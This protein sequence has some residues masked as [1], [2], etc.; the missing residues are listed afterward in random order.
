[1]YTM[2]IIRTTKK[3][4]E[5][6]FHITYIWYSYIFA[7]SKFHQFIIVIPNFNQC[8]YLSPVVPLP[9]FVTGRKY[10][11]LNQQHNS[12]TNYVQQNQG[13]CCSLE[14]AKKIDTT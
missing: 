10:K 6:K 8:S 9:I 1:M 13:L 12:I 11:Y 14:Y 4:D 5:Q 3:T 2:T 7:V